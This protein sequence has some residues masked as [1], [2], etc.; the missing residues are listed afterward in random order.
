MKEKEIVVT[1][2]HWEHGWEL[3]LGEDDATQVRSLAHAET[4][5]RDY[6]DTI[7]PEV[8]HSGVTVTLVPDSGAEEIQQARQARN[9]AERA[10]A[11][12]AEQIRE[13]V[14]DLRQRRGYSLS[15]TAA[16]L[17]VTRARVSQLE[18]STKVKA[19]AA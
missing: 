17:G 8:D 4:Q 3:I 15:D 5:V 16:L 14:T 9:E 1:V 18:N 2:R 19:G 6:L 10:A 13:V 11:E 7:E 12:A